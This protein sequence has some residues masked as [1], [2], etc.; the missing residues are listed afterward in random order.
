MIVPVAESSF[1]TLAGTSFFAS[2]G[3]LLTG[4]KSSEENNFSLIS[5]TGSPKARPTSITMILL[6][7]KQYDF[8]SCFRLLSAGGA[9]N[10]T[11]YSATG[12]E[13]IG[14]ATITVDGSIAADVPG[15]TIGGSLMIRDA[16]DNNREYIIR[17]DSYDAATGV[18]TLSNVDIV[19]ADAATSTTIT[20][21]GAF[22]TTKVGDLVL[23]K[24]RSNAVSYVK[25]VTDDNNIIID[26]PI[27]GQVATDA[28]E[29][30]ACPIIINTADDIY[31]SIVFEF[32]EVDGSASASM[33]YIADI[34]ARVVV[35]NRSEATT[36]IKGF[37]AAVTIG[38]AG[39]SSS[40]TRIEN[41]VYGS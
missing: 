32:K 41:T 1:G 7:L 30:N 4:Y 37:T 20:E 35:R 3:V 12:G 21:T 39:G 29:L 24:T 6:N 27:V 8:A 18:V 13:A 17:F 2:R 34:F 38:T 19:A 14:D 33:Q 26:P 10:K 15:K 16:S 28:I 22:A 5:A 40:A 25:T 9:L 36:K 23:N 31:F 11:E